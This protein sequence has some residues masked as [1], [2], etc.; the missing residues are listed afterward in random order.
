MITAILLV[1]YLCAGLVYVPQV[2]WIK[3]IPNKK[4]RYTISGI[5]IILSPIY[6]VAGLGNWIIHFVKNSNWKIFS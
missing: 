3:A 6:L 5:V 2:T 4:R 1:I